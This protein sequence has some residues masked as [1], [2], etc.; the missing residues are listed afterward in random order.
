MNIEIMRTFARLRELLV[1]H[2]DLSKP[3][4]FWSMEIAFSMITISRSPFSDR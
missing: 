2:A 3:I 4:R 1:S